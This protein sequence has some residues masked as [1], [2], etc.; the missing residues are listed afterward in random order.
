MSMAPVSDVDALSVAL[1]A[2]GLP[3]Q[4]TAVRLEGARGMALTLVCDR[5]WVE[6]LLAK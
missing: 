3:A 1:A 4:V 2:A 5:V 6:A